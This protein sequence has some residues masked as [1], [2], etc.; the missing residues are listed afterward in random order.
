MA[1]QTPPVVVAE[2]RVEDANEVAP[3]DE[4]AEETPEA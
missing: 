1:L 4:E 3:Q 2:P